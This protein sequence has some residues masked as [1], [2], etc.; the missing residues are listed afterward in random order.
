MA[1]RGRR[2]QNLRAGT[3]RPVPGP[4][5]PR[6]PGGTGGTGRGT[7]LRGGH[8]ESF[9]GFACQTALRPTATVGQGA[10]IL[11]PFYRNN[12]AV[13]HTDET[14]LPTERR[15]RASWNYH[16]FIH[17]S[18][19][20]TVTYNLTHLQRLPTSRQ[21]LL[22]L[23]APGAIRPE[24]VITRMDYTH[25]VFD[26]AGM[27]A[28]M[29]WREINGRN[30][31]SFCGAYWGMGFHEDGVRSGLAVVDAIDGRHAGGHGS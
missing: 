16:R 12:H 29:R 15:A 3:G 11:A 21:V 14:L 23:N 24:H 18:G 20:A 4:A 9:D 26:T 1:D 25:P 28:Q 19:A 31:S 22:T 10:E 17:D 27:N 30:R 13:L 2:L 5:A 6:Q 8:K 7:A